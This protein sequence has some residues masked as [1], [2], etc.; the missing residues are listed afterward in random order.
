MAQ[1]T[2]WMEGVASALRNC[3]ELIGD[4]VSA[5]GS[6]L[7]TS[8]EQSQHLD[9]LAH[10]DSMETCPHH[11]VNALPDD[12]LGTPWGPGGPGFGGMA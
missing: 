2:S 7:G 10:W 8:M 9:D 3:L 1:D 5:A 4:A 12:H 6:L 11:E